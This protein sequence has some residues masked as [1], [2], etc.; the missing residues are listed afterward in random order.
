MT[1]IIYNDLFICT[2]DSAFTGLPAKISATGKD[3]A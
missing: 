3:Q 1:D 2:G